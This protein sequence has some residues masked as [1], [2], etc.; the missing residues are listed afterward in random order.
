MI[1]RDVKV[2]EKFSTKSGKLF[3]KTSDRGEFY[4]FINAKNLETNEEVS[5]LMTNEVNCL[6]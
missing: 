3:V 2:G 1:F 5:F 4:S 6:N